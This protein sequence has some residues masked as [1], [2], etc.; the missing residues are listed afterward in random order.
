MHPQAKGTDP[1][2][3][4]RKVM[5]TF[6]MRRELITFL[7]GEADRRGL[8]LTAYVNRHLDGLRTWFGLPE[9][10][11]LPL[12]ADRQA[13]RMDRYEYLLHMAFQRGLEIHENGPGFDAPARKR[14]QK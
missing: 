5:Q 14:S 7:R 6:R 8:D 9:A 2:D 3:S 1:F 4:K 12:E 10:A 11:W 13:L